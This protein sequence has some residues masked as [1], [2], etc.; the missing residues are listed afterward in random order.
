MVPYFSSSSQGK[1]LSNRDTP[2]A[3]PT[4]STENERKKNFIQ[5]IQ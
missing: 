5:K 3:K 2:P 4:A 1:S